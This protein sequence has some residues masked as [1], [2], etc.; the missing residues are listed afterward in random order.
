VSQETYDRVTAQDARA[1]KLIAEIRAK[2]ADA[3][4]K[5]GELKP[6][7]SEKLTAMQKERDEMITAGVNRLRG[8]FGPELAPHFDKFVKERIGPSFKNVTHVPLPR[9]FDPRTDPR[10]QQM[11]KD[12]GRSK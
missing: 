2:G 7:F 11:F 10:V 5:P 6:E 1:K 12:P 9:D 3:F 8:E 4:G